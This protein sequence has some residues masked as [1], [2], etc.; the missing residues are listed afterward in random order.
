[1]EEQDKSNNERGAALLFVVTLCLLW[2]GL[3]TAKF[4]LLG[5]ELDGALRISS[6]VFLPAIIF[7]YIFLRQR[8]K[9]DNPKD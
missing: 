7:A 4:T 6:V 5:F 1:M 3:K 2:F 8:P 9:S